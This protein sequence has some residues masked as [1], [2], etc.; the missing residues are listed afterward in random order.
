VSDDLKGKAA[1]EACREMRD[2][3]VRLR[4]APQH[5][6]SAPCLHAALRGW[7]R[8]VEGVS[9][10]GDATRGCLPTWRARARGSG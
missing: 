8:M 9:R 10:V 7:A 3:V 2:A 5:L 6:L 4:A 1:I